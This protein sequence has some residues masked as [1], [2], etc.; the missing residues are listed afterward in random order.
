MTR[1]DGHTSARRPAVA[2]LAWRPARSAPG[3]RRSSAPASAELASHGRLVRRRPLT[4]PRRSRPGELRP[5]HAQPRRRR[6]RPR[7]P[8]RAHD[9][10]RRPCRP[11][12]RMRACQH[13]LPQP[14]QPGSGGPARTPVASPPTARPDRLRPLHAQPRHRHAR[15]G[16]PRPAQPG[17]CAG[18]HQRLRPLLAAVPRRGR[19]LPAPAARPAS[20][21]T[22]PGREP[23]AARTA[24][25]PA[26]RRG[27]AGAVATVA[28]RRRPPAAGRPGAPPVTTATVVRDRPGRRPC[29]PRAPSATPPADPVVNQLAGTYTALPARGTASGP[30]RSSTGSTTCR[31][32]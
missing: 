9:S 15:P 13:W 5:L 21:T 30:V 16:R 4:R 28:V 7:Q 26:G 32:C 19:R 11:P 24:P 14:Y 8:G 25:R 31:W 6:A 3:R 18:H 20:T 2:W 17:P 27:L 29:S 12:R 23:A 10:R 1:A 22:G